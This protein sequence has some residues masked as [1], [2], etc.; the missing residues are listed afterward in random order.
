VE[1]EVDEVWSIGAAITDRSF[2]SLFA[3]AL[4]VLFRRGTP[5][6]AVAVAT[7]AAF[8]ASLAA[9]YRRGRRRRL[10][11]RFFPFNF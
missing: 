9:R 5:G 8:L 10:R 6:R 1:A 3:A 11:H 7:A 4:D 2:L